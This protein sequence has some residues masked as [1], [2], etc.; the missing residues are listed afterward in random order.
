[1]ADQQTAGKTAFQEVVTEARKLFRDN[2]RPTERE[3]ILSGLLDKWRKAPNWQVVT[4]ANMIEDV[5]AQREPEGERTERFY[6]FTNEAIEGRSA[7]YEAF[8]NILHEEGAG[9]EDSTYRFMVNV[10]DAISDS[11]ATSADEARDAVD[12]IEPDVYTFDLTGWLH[13]HNGHTYFL[14]EAISEFG[15]DL[16]DGFSALA[17]AQQ[18][19]IREVGNKVI[20]ALEVAAAE[21]G[22]R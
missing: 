16:Q 3:R 19:H 1:M 7:L 6:S 9:G 22:Q 20:D 11:D 14:G 2:E 5:E 13:E 15:S 10:L 18:Y 12:D 8:S 17:M 21:R 4:P